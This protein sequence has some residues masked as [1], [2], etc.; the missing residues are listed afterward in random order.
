MQVFSVKSRFGTYPVIFGAGQIADGA[1]SIKEQ[2]PIF[3]SARAVFLV[4]TNT[5]EIAQKL[6]SSFPPNTPFIE[7]PNGEGSKTLET[8]EA[9]YK[10]LID[11]GYGRESW[12]INVGG[13]VVGD[14]GGFV[15]GTFMRGIPY[16][17]VPT[18]LMAQV[19]SS[20][21]GKVGVNLE[22]GKNLVGLF[23]PPKCVLVDSDVLQTL[24]LEELRS[25]FVE[26]YK[27]A[28]IGSNLLLDKIRKIKD[29]TVNE[30]A[31]LI[32]DAAEIKIDIVNEDE[33]ETGDKRILLN[34]G[35]TVGHA[36]E[37]GCDYQGITHGQAV[38]MGIILEQHF[39]VEVMGETNTASQLKVIV[40]DLR[41]FNLLPKRLPENFNLDR[42]SQVLASDKKASSGSILLPLI[43]P[44]GR[45]VIKS[46]ETEELAQFIQRAGLLRETLLG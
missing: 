29:V 21:G 23:N 35:H 14:L 5:R 33:F 31:P 15:A 2:A 45:P 13:G 6:S 38:A 25:G 43:D 40:S 37:A 10:A 24:P 12:L 46:V 36:I 7:I 26:V 44:S 8:V 11:I 19:D 16:I 42:A 20:I 9:V 27:A 18:T 41:R 39:N 3:N 1:N 4:D 22:A 30:V 34:L 32:Q 17:Q 28:L